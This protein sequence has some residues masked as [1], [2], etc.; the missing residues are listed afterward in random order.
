MTRFE[1]QTPAR[2]LCAALTAA[3]MGAVLFA[4]PAEAARTSLAGLL[5][6]LA[7]LEGTVAELK[8]ANTQLQTE[9]AEERADRQ[10]AVD[11]LLADVV[12]LQLNAV[13]GLADVLSVVEITPDDGGLG[14]AVPVPTVLFRGVNVQIVDGTGST[15]PDSGVG[16]NGLG[17]LIIGYDEADPDAGPLCSDGRFLT[18]AECLTEG[19]I[20][21]AN[22]KNG[23]HNLVVGPAHFYSQTG[24]V[25]FGSGNV[26]NGLGAVVSGGRLNT[27]SSFHSSVSGGALNT[28]SA[29]VSSVSGGSENTAGG[30]TSSVSGGSL[31]TASTNNSSVSGGRS[32]TASGANSSVSGGNRNTA[33]SLTS[34]VSGGQDNIASGSISSVS[35][36]EANTADGE[37][38]S[39][40]GGFFNT[41]SGNASSVSGGRNNTA[42]GVIS[43]V[44]GGLLNTASG[45]GS[46]VSGGFNNTAS[47]DRSSVSGGFG[48]SAPSAADWAAGSL[49]EDF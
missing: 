37:N 44:S 32:N 19:E 3:V 40:S 29:D 12:E 42:D 16:P 2:G 20:W 13:P 46:S 7:A 27:A 21:A 18:Q 45:A 36:G 10:A 11:A 30:P 22:Q 43:S 14:L 6:R 35:G 17:N 4:T 1:V 48:R 38:S 28:A 26:I 23:A 49:F 9:L 8:N 15:L 47:G 41:A 5:A 33:S 34:S 24:G 25:V 31:N 39:V